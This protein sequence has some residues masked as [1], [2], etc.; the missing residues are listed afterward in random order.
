MPAKP[1]WDAVARRLFEALCER[2]PD[3]YVVL[4]V[5]VVAPLAF[6]AFLM[7]FMIPQTQGFAP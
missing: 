2:L 3:R 6:G 4:T 5:L 1:E 7:A